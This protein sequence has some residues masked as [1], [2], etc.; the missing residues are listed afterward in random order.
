MTCLVSSGTLNLGS[1]INALLCSV[2]VCMTVTESKLELHKCPLCGKTAA[3]V[4]ELMV[5]Q[6]E[7]HSVLSVSHC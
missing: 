2:H 6:R 1:V 7:R 4:K 5:R 3:D